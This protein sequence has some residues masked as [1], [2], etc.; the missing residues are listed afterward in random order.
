MDVSINRH[1]KKWEEHQTYS[2]HLTH[3]RTR[4][5]EGSGGGGGGGGGGVD[6]TDPPP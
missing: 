3:G 4:G 2:A 1:C 5:G 6:A